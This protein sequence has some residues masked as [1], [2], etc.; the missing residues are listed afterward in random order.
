MACFSFSAGSRRS[1]SFIFAATAGSGCRVKA[2]L[3]LSNHQS[4]LDPVL[5]GVACNRR[6]NYL[7][8]KH[9]SVLRRWDG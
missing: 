7:R 1:W 2:A 4:H 6:L 5:V 3:V 9:F 8:A